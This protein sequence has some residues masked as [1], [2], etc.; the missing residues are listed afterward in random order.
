MDHLL[1]S[2]Q[3]LESSLTPIA[4]DVE[5]VQPDFESFGGRIKLSLN[6]ESSVDEISTPVNSLVRKP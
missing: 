4:Q 5:S 6:K 2:W 3:L 1:I